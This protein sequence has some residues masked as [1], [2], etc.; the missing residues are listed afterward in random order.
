[1]KGIGNSCVQAKQSVIERSQLKSAV[2]SKSKPQT[3]TVGTESN[4]SIVAKPKPV[5]SVQS[6]ED[7]SFENLPTLQRSFSLT[8]DDS[9]AD[10]PSTDL[11]SVIESHAANEIVGPPEAAPSS[12]TDAPLRRIGKRKAVE[13]L[14]EE[15]VE[16]SDPNVAFSKNGLLFDGSWNSVEKP[17]DQVFVLGDFNSPV[18]NQTLALRLTLPKNA[19]GW[20]FNITP[21]EDLSLSDIFFHF[22][23]RYKKGFIMQND[24]QGTW[25]A[26]VKVQID[27]GNHM[28]ST[29]IRASKMD[30]IVQIRREGFAVFI[31]GVF[32]VFFMHRRD[33]FA[34]AATQSVGYRIN[35]SSGFAN[36]SNESPSYSIN[37]LKLII[38][39]KDGN[40]NAEEIVV[41]QV[42]FRLNCILRLT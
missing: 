20:S 24:R 42:T 1:M 27:D 3:T 36:S 22:N 9:T 31:N 15:V 14:E 41:N 8:Y 29:A 12:S 16:N 13:A 26:P 35:S 18:Q 21:E 25:G 6:V 34:H 30:L 33:L 7:E 39:A 11:V 17:I 40:G 37:K 5:E 32:C 38:P 23:P 10:R 4:A 2:E 19:G 28:R